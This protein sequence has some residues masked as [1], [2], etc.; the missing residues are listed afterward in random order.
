MMQHITVPSHIYLLVI[1]LNSLF[2]VKIFSLEFERLVLT[3]SWTYRLSEID[4]KTILFSNYL[5]FK[6]KTR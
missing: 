4:K 2:Q 1:Y 3:N 6:I 5:L